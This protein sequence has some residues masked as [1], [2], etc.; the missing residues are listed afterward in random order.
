[1]YS[2]QAMKPSVTPSSGPPNAAQ[3]RRKSRSTSRARHL[4]S[5]GTSSVLP[6]TVQH[7]RDRPILFVLQGH[8]QG[9][10]FPIGSGRSS[11][12]REAS[13]RVS[14]SDDTVSREH[15]YLSRENGEVYLEDLSSL[16]GTFV[17]GQRLDGR[18]RLR[19]GD[20]LRFGDHT[21]V[22]FSLVDELEER[23][24]CTLF[25]LAA[26]DPLT[27]L[28]NRRY[29]DDRLSG[30][31]AFARRHGTPV[32]L[33]L[34]DIDHFKVVNDTYGHPAGDAVLKQVAAALLAILRP[35]DV[36]ARFGGEEFIVIARNISREG[37]E[38]FGERMRRAISELEFPE[39]ALDITV[40]VGVAC[41]RPGL[42]PP[43]PKALL[44]AADAALYRAKGSGRNCVRLAT[45][46]PDIAS[47]RPSGD[48][49]PPNSGPE[50]AP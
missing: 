49:V 17:N 16:N 12:G 45:V 44:E 46:S 13:A 28:Y 29:F 37:A 23:A 4:T 38:S 3:S 48:T 8:E 33:L 31:L 39:H 1:M 22:D 34:V 36:L 43:S 42:P 7:P 26:R 50:V 25:E 15:A 5:L 32:A 41:V 40:S 2:R 11:I 24:L 19:S 20:R 21:I 30:E 35:E 9:A 6:S 27:R 47:A 18:I 14:L 10:V